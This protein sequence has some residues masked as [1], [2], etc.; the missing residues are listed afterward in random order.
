MACGIYKI[1]NCINGKI[2]IG[3]S[4]NIEMRMYNHY[5]SALR[6]KDSEYDTYLSRAIRK[7]GREN[8][9][10]EI[11]EECSISELPVRE[12][13]W[14]EHYNST[15]RSIG[16][17]ISTG[18]DGNSTWSEKDTNAIISFYK[19]GKTAEEIAELVGRTTSSIQ[20]RLY[21]LG[22]KSPKYWTEGELQLLKE[23]VSVNK[24]PVEI[25]GLLG[26]TT[27]SVSHQMQRKGLKRKHYW[28]PEEEW[29]LLEMLEKDTPIKYIAEELGRSESSIRSKIWRNK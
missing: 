14:I 29:L 18:G 15:D 26:R 24:T 16:Y 7:Y 20:N 8:F 9:S 25:A 4:I 13:Y 21:L 1:T 17:N 11:I 6:P 23:L 3:L 12:R 27:S 22:I 2:Y 10:H 5:W 19:L 28:T